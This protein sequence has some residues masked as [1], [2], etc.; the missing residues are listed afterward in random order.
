M[1]K[2]IL[3]VLMLL[4]QM[5]LFGDLAK[6]QALEKEMWDYI[7]EHK[8]GD[9]DKKIAPYFQAV[10]FDGPRSKEQYMSRAKA[11]HI[12]DY[13]FNNFQVTDGPGIM[14]VTYTVT[15]AETISGKRVFSDAYR[16]SV[17]QERN[18]NWQWISHSI[19]IPVSES[20]A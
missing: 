7:K 18:G 1:L 14:V 17:W 19:L 20:A 13:K 15:V 11:L 6:G 8:W 12:S 3:V 9:L 16:L 5:A 4:S 2:R 10:L